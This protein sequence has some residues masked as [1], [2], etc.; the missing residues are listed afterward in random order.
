EAYD[1]KLASGPSSVDRFL[2]GKGRLSAKA[3]EGLDLFVRTGCLGCH[4]GPYFSDG[5]YHDLDLPV[6]P[7][8]AATANDPGRARG[9]VMLR[10]SEFNSLSSFYD[11]APGEPV[12]LVE[13]VSTATFDPE[14]AFLTP[15]L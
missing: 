14:G 10:A 5:K 11:R 1:R 8:L 2:G 13:D 6:P 3:Q 12:E 9:L 4:D 7:Y 15:S